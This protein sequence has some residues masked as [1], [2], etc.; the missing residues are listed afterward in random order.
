MFNNLNII[1]RFFEEP[2]REF[3]V[4]EIARLMDISPATASKNL[5]ELAK[6]K[7]LKERKER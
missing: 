2:T 4:R 5:K 1:R 7:I 6:E 3:N